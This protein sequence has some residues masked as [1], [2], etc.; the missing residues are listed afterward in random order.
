MSERE[1]MELIPPPSKEVQDE[2]RKAAILAHKEGDLQKAAQRLESCYARSLALP[3]G[4]ND[5]LYY[6]SAAIQLGLEDLISNSQFI[7]SIH[8]VRYEQPLL[9]EPSSL[10]EEYTRYYR[11]KEDAHREGGGFFASLFGGRGKKGST[12]T[13]R[14][15]ERERARRQAYGLLNQAIEMLQAQQNLAD[16]E[17]L[18]EQAVELF[19]QV[20]DQQGEADALHF[21]GRIKHEM[22]QLDGA[23]ALYEQ[24]LELAR[25]ND[26]PAQIARAM[27]E[28]ARIF[29]RRDYHFIKAEE[30][31]RYGLNYY[32]S[33]QDAANLQVSINGLTRL[34]EGALSNDE[35]F[36]PT[37]EKEG[38][39][40]GSPVAY[41]HIR[42]VAIKA[43]FLTHYNKYMDLLLK[44]TDQ[45]LERDLPLARYILREAERI[46]TL[47]QDFSYLR[48]I[49]VL[50]GRLPH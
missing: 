40:V 50:K 19:R 32:A 2:I 5:L 42:G 47:H 7:V 39:P 48:E 24:A 44:W 26:Y 9:Q 27:H 3:Y 14:P 28:R 35:F 8:Y 16:A 45:E 23:L 17:K 4:T 1:S 46:A 37:L 10:R 22:N 36:L 31:Y 12:K 25:Y 30:G 38:V 13:G 6:A 43:E 29:E 18:A 34:A 21:Q 49:D 33:I 15:S 20:Q 41:L 11:P